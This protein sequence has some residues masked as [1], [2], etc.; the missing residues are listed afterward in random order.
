M[1]RCGANCLIRMACSASRP[2][3]FQSML[4]RGGPS[5]L[6]EHLAPYAEAG[7]SR[8]VISIAGGD[9]FRQTELVAEAR[10]L[11]G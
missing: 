2:R 1:M 10:A 3:R 5:T 4:V 9:W 8:L 11:L 6:A 7:A